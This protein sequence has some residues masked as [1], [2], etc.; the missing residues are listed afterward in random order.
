MPNSEISVEY[1]FGLSRHAGLDRQTDSILDCR[2]IHIDR[3][4]NTKRTAK[5]LGRGRGADLK[6]DQQDGGRSEINEIEVG[7]LLP[8]DSGFR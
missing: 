3:N 7:N 6:A 4:R 1:T 5:R 8:V 2:N